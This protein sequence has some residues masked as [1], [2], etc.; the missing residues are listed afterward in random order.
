MYWD[1]ELKAFLKKCVLSVFLNKDTENNF[2]VND[3]G[4]HLAGHSIIFNPCFTI[5][6]SAEDFEILLPY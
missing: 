6:L 5:S 4:V 1:Y 3:P 2:I